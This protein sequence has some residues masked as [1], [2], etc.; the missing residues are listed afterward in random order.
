MAPDTS[1]LAGRVIQ[2]RGL[3]SQATG[4][5]GDVVCI[6]AD[7]RHV[8]LAPV[9]PEGRLPL[10]LGEPAV[11]QFA[12]STGLVIVTG[13]FAGPATV[14]VNGVPQEALRLDLGPG[15]LERRN[16]R[17]SFRVALALNG[18]FL[19]LGSKELT[20]ALRDLWSRP[21]KGSAL[22]HLESLARSLSDRA[23]PCVLKDLSL[24]GA[25]LALAAPTPGPGERA[26]LHVALDNQEWVRN[27]P[28]VVVQ[29]HSGALS[30]ALDAL[31]RLRFASL[32]PG[33][34]GRLGRYLARAQLEQLKRGVRA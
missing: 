32:P 22:P 19:P 24:G 4:A 2:H 5:W 33:I 28:C 14:V 20:E 13:I 23:R 6:D 12:E 8:D 26:L 17:D 31:V 10:L 27:L 15:A 30:G 29:A 3:L 21:S 11:F 34:E 1:N 18:E 9:R 7:D 25:R 16:R